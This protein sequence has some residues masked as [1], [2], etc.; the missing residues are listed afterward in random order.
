MTIGAFPI[1]DATCA[2]WEKSYSENG[3][4]VS[5]KE[6]RLCRGFGEEDLFIDEGNVVNLAT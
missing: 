2:V 3:R 5:I 4:V 6:H 1:Q